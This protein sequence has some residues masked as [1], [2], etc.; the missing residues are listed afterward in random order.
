MTH[1]YTE[2]DLLPL[3]ALQRLLFCR[4]QCAL[5]HIEQKLRENDAYAH[6]LR[7]D[8]GTVVYKTVRELIGN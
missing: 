1:T 5:T 6:C 8:A 7:L 3:S 4:R 2:D